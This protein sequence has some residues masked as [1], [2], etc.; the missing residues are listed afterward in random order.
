[1]R[2]NRFHIGTLVILVLVL[3]VSFAALRESNDLWDSGLFTVTFG[4]FLIAILL[5]VHRTE[6]N[7]A[8]WLGFALFG[9]GYLAVSPWSRQL[10]RG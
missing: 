7:R 3:G 5:A 1:M 9:W 8:F 2:R 10:N 4:V 6:S